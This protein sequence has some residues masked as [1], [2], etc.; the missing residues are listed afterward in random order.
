MV[1]ITIVYLLAACYL[2]NK[3]GIKIMNDSPRYL[4]YAS[5]IK[6]GFYIDPLNIWYFTYVLFIYAI[7]LVLDG[8]LA[9]IIGQYLLGLLAV[10]ALFK[11]AKHLTNNI[12]IAA[13][14]GLLFIV[15]PDNIFWHSYIL[16]ESVYS[17][18]ICICL[19]I[20]IKY[21]KFKEAN[22]LL[23]LA[24]ILPLCFFSRPTSPALM[25]AIATPALYKFYT[26]PERRLIKII[27]SISLL[28]V[29]LMLA[30]KMLTMH[31]VMFIYSKGDIIF[32]MHEM[33]HSP[34]YSLL[35]VTPPDDLF[36]PEK[37]SPLLYQMTT[38]ISNNLI[39]WVKLF[40]GKFLAFTSHVRPYWSWGHIIA[41]I[42]LIWPSYYFTYLTIKNRLISGL[43][44]KSISV[45][46][47]IH[48]LIVSGTWADWDARF[49]VPIFP[50]LAILTAIGV[51]HAWRKPFGEQK[52]LDQNH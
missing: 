9:I 1:F 15:Y 18:L 5:N 17:S 43:L 6:S 38:F 31:S 27:G 37:N 22:Y 35:S 51:H 23:G 13:L 47:L 40:V 50:V 39:F 16:T 28:F 52:S 11:T 48:S 42:T 34:Y 46:V 25:L 14:A 20:L 4:G 33:P 8:L 3:Y 10:L 7:H 21:I 2:F 12:N 45:Y 26:N 24:I 49:F 32:A 44:L 41:S 30:N 36:M 19:Y 29:L